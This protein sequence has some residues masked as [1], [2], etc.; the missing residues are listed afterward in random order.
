MSSLNKNLSDEQ[1]LESSRYVV[2][3]HH[4]KAGKKRKYTP[5]IIN[6][7]DL[8]T[9]T[10]LALTLSGERFIQF[11]SN[12]P[13]AIIGYASPFQLILLNSTT[14]TDQLFFDGTFKCCPKG[15]MQRLTILVKKEREE[16]ETT[17]V[18]HAFMENKRELDYLFLWKQV[19]KL[20]SSLKRVSKL[21]ITL[22]FEKAVHKAIFKTFSNTVFVACQF[23]LLQAVLTWLKNRRSQEDI[24]NSVLMKEKLMTN[25]RELSTNGDINFDEKRNFFFKF[26]KMWIMNLF[27]IWLILI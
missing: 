21:Y 23:H 1:L 27:R 2:R 14:E 18:L 16:V 25:I 8:D 7:K 22:D 6:I 11:S 3:E 26:W 10:H 13:E 15:I 24:I 9:R 5:V 20:C 12:F 19:K 17:P 4:I